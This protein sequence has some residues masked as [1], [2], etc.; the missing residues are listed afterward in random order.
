M[1]DIRKEHEEL[2]RLLRKKP[3]RVTSI[4]TPTSGML[5]PPSP[6]TTSSPVPP[7][8]AKRHL[9]LPKKRQQQQQNLLNLNDSGT[10]LIRRASD[11]NLDRDLQAQ[12]QVHR[13][14][15]D[16]DEFDALLNPQIPSSKK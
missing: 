7:L 6:T 13:A 4:T 5:T 3:N 1:S 2:V 12:I 14:E 11:V 10:E 16:D 8:P 15:S 9:P